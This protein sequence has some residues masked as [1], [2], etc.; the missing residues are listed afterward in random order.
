[1]TNQPSYQNPLMDIREGMRVYDATGQEIGRVDRVHLG[2]MRRE[3]PQ[4]GVSKSAAEE[5]RRAGEN[6]PKLDLAQAFA[7][8]RMPEKM[9]RA[10]LLKGYILI[11]GGPLKGA[12]R[13]IMP[14]RIAQVA[15][16]GVRLASSLHNLRRFVDM[17]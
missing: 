2:G 10:L 14:E 8:D 1:M 7:P 13:Y 15:D 11:G 6:M 5:L 17:D 12:E 4:E 16:D 9:A 3:D